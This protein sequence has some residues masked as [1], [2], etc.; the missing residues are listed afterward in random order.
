M[1]K[2]KPAYRLKLNGTK[3]EIM[4]ADG[5]RFTLDE[6]KAIVGPNPIFTGTRQMETMVLNYDLYLNFDGTQP[7]NE[8][9]TKIMMPAKM[10]D[11]IVEDALGEP[12]VGPCYRFMKKYFECDDDDSSMPREIKIIDANE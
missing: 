5:L 9:A 10:G 3:E 12:L 6:I 8:Q 4:P 2:L 7:L 1:A 11:D